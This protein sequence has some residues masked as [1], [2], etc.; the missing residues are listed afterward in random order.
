MEMTN[1]IMEGADWSSDFRVCFSEI[2]LQANQI[3]AAVLSTEST[4]S[5]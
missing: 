3:G 1:Q 5:L 2:L 4:N